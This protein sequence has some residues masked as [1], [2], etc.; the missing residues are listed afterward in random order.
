MDREKDRI[1]S[2]PLSGVTAEIL[3]VIATTRKGLTRILKIKMNEEVYVMK[4]I[5]A[6]FN[7]GV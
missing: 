3:E 7:L 5:W 6:W 1:V 2:Y 4:V